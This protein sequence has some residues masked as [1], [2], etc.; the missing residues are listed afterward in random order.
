[1]ADDNLIEGMKI[2]LDKGRYAFLARKSDF[3]CVGFFNPENE[4]P[5][6]AF[7]LSSQAMNALVALYHHQTGKPFTW[8]MNAW[9]DKGGHWQVAKVLTVVAE[10]LA[11][12]KQAEE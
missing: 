2:D 8:G 9:L 10:P 7:S 5:A 1:M 4:T 12:T 3:W 11:D 6:L